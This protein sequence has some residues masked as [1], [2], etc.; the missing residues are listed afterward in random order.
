LGQF[1]RF[2]AATGRKPG[3][4]I[5]AWG[6]DDRLPVIHVTWHDAVAYAKWAGARL[7]TEAEWE[8]AARGTDGREFVWGNAWP[9]PRGV[10]NFSDEAARKRN[11]SWSAQRI[12]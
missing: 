9:P 3:G 8:R 6:S 2:M 5:E 7:P 12:S 1:R 10:G 4:A 11:P